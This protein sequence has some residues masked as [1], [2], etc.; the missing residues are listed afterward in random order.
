MHFFSG[1]ASFQ[2]SSALSQ[3]TSP[4]KRN[5][6]SFYA[7]SPPTPPKRQPGRSV[8]GDSHKRL[9]ASQNTS[10]NIDSFSPTQYTSTYRLGFRS[11]STAGSS[12][13]NTQ[14]GDDPYVSQYDDSSPRR[15]SPVYYT[16]M[17]SSSPPTI[18]E[19]Q[20]PPF[21]THETPQ[22]HYPHYF[23]KQDHHYQH[24]QQHLLQPHSTS[25]QHHSRSMLEQNYSY[26]RGEPSYSREQKQRSLSEGVDDERQQWE[27]LLN[28]HNQ[29]SHGEEK[30]SSQWPPTTKPVSGDRRADPTVSFLKQ[31]DE[32]PPQALIAWQQY[33]ASRRS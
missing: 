33:S 24:Q 28:R 10:S 12:T 26:G 11:P 20:H 6:A 23:M 3:P 5:G 7:S 2:P 13:G 4:V 25:L 30:T 8:H 32:K 9:F 14:Y 18:Q 27:E 19:Q 31:H 21:S 1:A 16:Q 29:M 17:P 22:P 15:L